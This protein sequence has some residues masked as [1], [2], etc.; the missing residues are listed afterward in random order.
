M[1]YLRESAEAGPNKT[2][3]VSMLTRDIELQDAVLDLLDNCI[4]GVVRTLEA[5]DAEFDPDVPYDGFYARITMNPDLFEIS[6]NCGGIPKDIAQK[7]AFM[8]GRPNEIATG[9][10]TVGRYGIGMK[11]AIFKMGHAATV[12]SR[13]GNETFVVGISAEWMESPNDW[14]LPMLIRTGESTTP[15][16]TRIKIP[17]LRDE[18]SAKF[19]KN[20][21]KFIEFF[22]DYV[23]KHYSMIISKGFTVVINDVKVKAT[24]FRLFVGTDNLQSSNPALA[25][26]VLTIE[27]SEVKIEIYAGLFRRVPTDEE[28]EREEEFKSTRDESGWTIVCNDRVVLYRDR[29][30]ITGWGTGGVPSWHTQ[31]MAFGGI[32]I[33]SANDVT[34]LP[35]T[36]TK[37]GVDASSRLYAVILDY[38]REATK[39]FTNFTN[40]WKR[41]GDE[42]TSDVFTKARVADLQAIRT[43]ASTANTSSIKKFGGSLP[44]L[45]HRPNLPLPQNVN[46]NARISY[47]KPRAEVQELGRFLFEDPNAKPKD[48][49]EQSFDRLLKAV[50]SGKKS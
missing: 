16:G 21:D 50:R 9:L 39:S 36:T 10:P 20:Q 4:D 47:E 37:R 11:R 13:H 7:R 2:F 34:K 15:E 19:D 38:M 8:M 46:R 17:H 27:V 12:S 43:V 18:I 44:A 35:L 3:F 29:T 49:G 5:Q 40:K 48:V 23:S 14:H 42:L 26:Y 45:S 1:R 28:L 31:F 6:D 41:A 32:V 33:L 22:S 30:H 24:P 25:P